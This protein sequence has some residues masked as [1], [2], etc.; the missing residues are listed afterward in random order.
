MRLHHGWV[1]VD[2]P[3]LVLAALHAPR[4]RLYRPAYAHALYLQEMRETYGRWYDDG[5]RTLRR[6]TL[7]EIEKRP[8]HDRAKIARRPKAKK[9]PR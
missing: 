2:L 1:S 6:Q 8:E 5:H 4:T 7:E 3:L 9:A